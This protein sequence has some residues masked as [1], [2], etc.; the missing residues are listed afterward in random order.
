MYCLRNQIYMT[1]AGTSQAGYTGLPF[2]LNSGDGDSGAIYL[3]HTSV[4]S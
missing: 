3:L 1:G 4:I 2:K